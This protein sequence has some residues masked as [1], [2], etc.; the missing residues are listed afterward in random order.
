MPYGCSG[1]PHLLGVRGLGQPGGRSL[2]PQRCPQLATNFLSEFLIQ[3]A[4]RRL[5]FWPERE[6]RLPRHFVR[7]RSGFFPFKLGS[8]TGVIPLGKLAESDPIRGAIPVMPCYVGTTMFKRDEGHGSSHT[9]AAAQ[10]GID[11]LFGQSPVD[12][13]PAPCGCRLGP[14]TCRSGDHGRPCPFD[15]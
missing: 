6:F 5:S 9:F 7:R 3:G 11:P 8:A 15:L 14:G 12:H 1:P 4:E 10:I 2:P 13:D